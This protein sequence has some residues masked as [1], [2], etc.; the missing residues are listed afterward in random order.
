MKRGD[1]MK[2]YQREQFMINYFFKKR[3]YAPII[4]L[5][6]SIVCLLLGIVTYKDIWISMVFLIAF[7]MQILFFLFLKLGVFYRPFTKEEVDYLCEQDYA[8][9][10]EKV[11]KE[12]FSKV[13]LEELVLDPLEIKRPQVYPEKTHIIYRYD[14]E[15]KTIQYTHAKYE[16]LLFGKQRLYYYTSC[17][18]YVSGISGF[19]RS[20]E[21]DYQ[22]I[23]LLETGTTFLAP[24][25][26]IPYG[27]DQLTLTFTFKN[28]EPLVIVLRATPRV[29]QH[30]APISMTDKEKVLVERMREV[31]RIYK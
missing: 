12:L 25:K 7:V 23:V 11:K 30:L 29:S 26:E 15:T 9:L 17:L 14:K 6:L 24:S 19:D 28:G 31:I 13:T 10:Y 16:W 4:V 27:T 2:V 1:K 22:D 8:T 20:L 5:V 3:Y 18:D 21:V